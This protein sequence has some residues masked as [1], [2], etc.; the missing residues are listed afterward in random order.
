MEAILGPFL[1]NTQNQE[2]LFCLV[3][4]IWIAPCLLTGIKLEAAIY[5]MVKKLPFPHIRLQAYSH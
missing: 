1:E 5:K 4:L 2:N 3:I